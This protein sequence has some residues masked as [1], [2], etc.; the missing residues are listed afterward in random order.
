MRVAVIGASGLVGRAMVKRFSATPITH[1]ELDVTDDVAVRRILGKLKPEVV[2]NCAVLSVDKCE[3]DKSLAH[4][5]NVT[6]P[7]AI[8]EWTEK[9]GGAIVHFSSN[10]V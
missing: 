5:I 6:G 1:A 2:I 7:A 3:E 4:E 9:T 8:A 10:Y